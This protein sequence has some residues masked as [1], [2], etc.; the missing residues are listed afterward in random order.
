MADNK[1]IRAHDLPAKLLK[2]GCKESQSDGFLRHHY[3][4][5]DAEQ[6]TQEVERCRREGDI[7]GKGYEQ[8]RQQPRDIARGKCG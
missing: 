5:L 2:L 7:H 8:L 1:T 6:G 3:G 4:R